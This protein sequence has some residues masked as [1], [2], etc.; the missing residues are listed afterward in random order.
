MS[1]QDTSKDNIIGSEQRQRPFPVPDH[2]RFKID[3]AGWLCFLT[4]RA[5]DGLWSE[6]VYLEETFVQCQDWN[7][8]EREDAACVARCAWQDKA[9]D[10]GYDEREDECSAEA[11]IANENADRCRM[12]L[13][14]KQKGGEP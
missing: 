9:Y 3:D 4:M 14:L 13:Y 11:W 5:S 10:L 6:G 7:D 12:W 1:D 8:L 2:S